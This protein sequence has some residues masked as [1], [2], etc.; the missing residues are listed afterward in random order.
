M[1][2]NYSDMVE[3]GLDEESIHARMKLMSTAYWQSLMSMSDQQIMQGFN[4]MIKVGYQLS[5]VKLSYN[6]V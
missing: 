6:F 3:A 1:I 4:E 5:Q 2:G